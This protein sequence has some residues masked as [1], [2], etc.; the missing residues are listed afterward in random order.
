MSVIAMGKLV[1]N[2]SKIYIKS[3]NITKDITFSDTVQSVFGNNI[4]FIAEETDN[5]LNM[6]S[7]DDIPTTET[8]EGIGKYFT[9]I[10]Y[11]EE[12]Y[13]SA[14][15]IDLINI[16]ET[17]GRLKISSITDIGVDIYTSDIKNLSKDERLIKDKV[18]DK[19]IL[20]VKARREDV[21][22]DKEKNLIIMNN[23]ICAAFSEDEI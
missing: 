5:G 17:D 16:T 22:L 15:K 2:D 13:I 3:K 14:L 19:D 4:I 6:V 8:C 21:I 11:N 18:Y 10:V 1:A 12:F 9:G 20:F 7:I 23:A